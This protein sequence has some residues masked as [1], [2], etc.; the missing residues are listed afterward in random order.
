V[1]GDYKYVAAETSENELYNLKQD[2]FEL[3]N[4]VDDPACANI[5][6]E[7]HERIVEHINA[8]NDQLAKGKLT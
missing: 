1:R 5:K 8:T 4:L 2:P 6:K 7:L 3:K